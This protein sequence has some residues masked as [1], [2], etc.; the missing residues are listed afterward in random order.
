M[1]VDRNAPAIAR[2][3]ITIAAPA[4]TVWAVHTDIDAWPRWHP[5]ITS[6]ELHGPLQSGSTFTW[7][8]G[9]G[10]ITSRLEIVEPHRHIVWT[11]KAVGTRAIHVWTLEPDADRTRVTT[12]ESMAG[13]P[14]ALFK[15][16][17]QRMLDRT[18]DAWVAGL[19]TAAEA[20][21]PD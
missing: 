17:F 13:R 1:D 10:T 18:L 5:D 19:K 16:Y 7:K 11:G 20:S 15:S 6:T 9:P 4:E 21:A 8:S 3:E 14:V 2:K 12:E